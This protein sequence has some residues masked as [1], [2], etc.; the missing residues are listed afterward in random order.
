VPYVICVEVNEE[1]A[2][3]P[4]ESKGLAE[5]AFHPEEV[6]ANPALR[7]DT[8]YYLAQQVGTGLGAVLVLGGA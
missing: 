8:D 7:V 5:R 2:V 6:N 1:G 3:L 4:R